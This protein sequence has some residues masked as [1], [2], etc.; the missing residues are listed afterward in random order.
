LFNNCL[1]SSITNYKDFCDK[2]NGWEFLLEF[3]IN[4]QKFIS[5]RKTDNAAKIFLNNED[6]NIQKS[7]ECI[8]LL[9]FSIPDGTDYLSFRS[10]ILFFLRPA[11]NTEIID[12]YWQIGKELPGE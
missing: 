3:K 7:K 10:L 8:E 6:L 1:G 4:E 5:V 11:V 9:C 2:L 12:L